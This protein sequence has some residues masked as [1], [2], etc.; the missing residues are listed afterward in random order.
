MKKRMIDIS[1]GEPDPDVDDSNGSEMSQ[2][3]KDSNGGGEEAAG[4]NVTIPRAEYEELKG[5]V[6]E[7]KDS[8]LRV[9]ADFD[10]FRKRME[11]E[12]ENI[13]CYANERLISDLLPILDNLDRALESAGEEMQ[14]QRVLDGVRMIAGQ[15]HGVLE[16]CGLEPLPSVGQPFDPAHHEAVGV[17]PS[18]EH[19]EGTVIEELQR[20]YSLRGRVVR[21][22]KVHVA[23]QADEEK[24]GDA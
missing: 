1:T 5:Q 22:S 21:P 10:N 7:L 17:L 23:G 3:E 14:T 12:R 13:I 15:L 20:G 2:D 16:Q 4:Q 24:E 19:K 9:A 18:E 6:E 8:Y 11:R